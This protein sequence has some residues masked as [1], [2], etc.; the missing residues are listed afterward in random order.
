MGAPEATRKAY[1]DRVEG[2]APCGSVGIYEFD[3]GVVETLGATVHEVG[4]DFGYYIVGTGVEPPPSLPG[5]PVVFSNP[6][7]YEGYV[8]PCIVVTRDDI[9]PAMNRWHPGTVQYRVPKPGALPVTVTGP[10]GQQRT[11]YSHMIQRQ[12]GIPYDISYSIQVLHHKRGIA[13]R[14]SGVLLVT[15]VMRI[16]QPYCCVKVVDSVN[17]VRLYSATAE[18]VGSQDELVDVAD[19]VTGW[20]MNLTV[21]ALL[22]LLDEQELVSAVDRRFT[23]TPRRL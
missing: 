2:R 13:S 21:E 15:H 12:Q 6:E 7:E 18:A 4:D 5:I 1:L 14:R 10:G 20:S 19:R 23:V 16:Y 17:D 22:D 3:R 8:L 11:G 9:S